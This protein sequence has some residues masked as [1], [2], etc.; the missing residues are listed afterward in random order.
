M[1]FATSSPNFIDQGGNSTNKKT[2]ARITAL[3]LTNPPV[4]NVFCLHTGAR[5]VIK[6]LR[7]S[8][9]GWKSTQEFF[10]KSLEKMGDKRIVG[11]YVRQCTN[12]I[13]KCTM[14]FNFYATLFNASQ[15]YSDQ[16]R[17]NLFGTDALYR[18]YLQSNEKED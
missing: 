3:N 6:S 18:H 8:I 10:T 11:A 5:D 13:F 17:H 9:T 2:M 7:R 4:F 16:W 12:E 14:T 15:T 1:S